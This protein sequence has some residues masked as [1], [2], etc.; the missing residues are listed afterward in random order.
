MMTKIKTMNMRL[1]ELK[2]IENRETEI[3]AQFQ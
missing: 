2:A 1:N 3:I